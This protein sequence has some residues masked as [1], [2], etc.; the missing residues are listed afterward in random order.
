VKISADFAGPTAAE[1]YVRYRELPDR[2]NFEVASASNDPRPRLLIAAAQGGNYYVFVHGREGAG[3]GTPFILRA[4]TAAL[5]SA[6]LLATRRF[7]AD[8]RSPT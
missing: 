2:S 8:G 4:E 1:V 5:A 6:A 3:A 7:G